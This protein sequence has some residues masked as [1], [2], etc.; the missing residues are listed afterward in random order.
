MPRNGSGTDQSYGQQLSLQSTEERDHNEE[1]YQ[2]NKHLLKLQE[3][4]EIDR[5]GKTRNQSARDDEKDEVRSN[6]VFIE[7]NDNDLFPNAP[8]KSTLGVSDIV[9][10]VT[11]NSPILLSTEHTLLNSELQ[12]AK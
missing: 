3:L 6:L 11:Q 9:R 2:T 5:D 4:S 10:E 1:P 12:E 7:R 8:I